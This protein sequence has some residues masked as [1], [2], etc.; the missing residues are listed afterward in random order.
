MLPTLSKLTATTVSTAIKP[1][2]PTL[3]NFKYFLSF[4]TRWSDNDMYGHLNNVKYIEYT[5]AIV[6]E[7]LINHCQL[8]PH[9][10]IQPVGLVINS[11]FTYR[12]S[13]NYPNP[14]IA[15]LAVSKLLG[16][17]PS[18]SF[19][20]SSFL[21]VPFLPSHTTPLFVFELRRLTFSFFIQP[22]LPSFLHTEVNHQ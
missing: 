10:L 6:N 17:F 15:A 9:S 13:L 7:F 14:I 11:G 5:D 8:N 4:N 2:L 19:P 1:I 18:P 12:S 21:F 22:F 3:N 16:S 20:F